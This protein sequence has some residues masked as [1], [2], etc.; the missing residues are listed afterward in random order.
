[1]ARRRERRDLQHQ[2][3]YATR[4]L[5]RAGVEVDT[6]DLHAEIDITLTY[7]ENRRRVVLPHVKPENKPTLRSL[8]E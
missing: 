3:F 2:I 8:R 5:E 6:L 1:M 4:E 7:Q